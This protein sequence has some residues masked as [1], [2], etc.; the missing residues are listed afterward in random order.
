MMS[1]QRNT[2]THTTAVSS[3]FQNHSND[4]GQLRNKAEDIYQRC[5][6]VE[7]KPKLYSWEASILL[8]S[9]AHHYRNKITTIV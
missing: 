9:H 6:A 4:L 8:C 5:H 1:G 2:N 7:L 3:V